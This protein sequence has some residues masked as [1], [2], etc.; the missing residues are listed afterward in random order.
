MIANTNLYYQTSSKC[1]FVQWSKKKVF[2]RRIFLA[3]Q[4]ISKYSMPFTYF[5]IRNYSPE[6]INDEKQSWILSY[7]GWII[8]ILKKN[9][10]GIFALLY[11]PSTKQNLALI[12]TRQSKFEWQ[13]NFLFSQKKL[14]YNIFNDNTQEQ[15]I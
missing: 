12:L 14:N 5:N 6:V 10:H 4:T 8:S 15:S 9:L 11:N 13:Y 7:R 3:L 1:L 2:A